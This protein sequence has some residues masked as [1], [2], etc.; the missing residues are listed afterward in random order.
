MISHEVLEDETETS[1]G[2]ELD[3]KRKAET[4]LFTNENLDEPTMAKKVKLS[5]EEDNN[6][7]ENLNE[8][9]DDALYED[10]KEEAV[11]HDENPSPN[12]SGIEGSPDGPTGSSG[13]LNPSIGN[14][15]LGIS[16]P[17]CVMRCNFHIKQTGGQISLEATFLG[18]SLGKDGLNQ[19]M[20]YI[21]NQIY[22]RN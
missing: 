13:S 17:E 8:S 18:G 20:Q 21:K 11:E 3:L 16:G 15:Q 10:D 6:E 1:T 7:R 9:E 4:S 2:T 12:D 5:S 14:A 22:K 19:L